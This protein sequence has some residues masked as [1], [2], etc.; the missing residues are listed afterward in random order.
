MYIGSLPYLIEF[1]SLKYLSHM[2]LACEHEIPL[3]QLLSGKNRGDGDTN[4]PQ[5]LNDV[6]PLP[7]LPWLFASGIG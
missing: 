4:L 3:P 6:L 7:F 2:M 5:A 1:H